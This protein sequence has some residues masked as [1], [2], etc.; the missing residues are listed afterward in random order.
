[1]PFS[2][3]AFTHLFDWE[4]DPQRQEKIVNSR[5]EAE[6]D[7]IDT[8]LSSLAAKGFASGTVMLFVQT[9]A[10]TGWTKGTTHNNKALR[11]VTGSVGSGGTIAFTT[12][13]GS[14]S[15]DAT[16]ITAATMP[17][18]GHNMEGFNGNSDG[19]P[20]TTGTYLST[21]TA[22]GSGLWRNSTNISGGAGIL[23]TGSGGSHTHGIDLSVQYVDVIIATKD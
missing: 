19:S 9:N 12:A 11:V 13:F 20:A 1:M 14:R 15:T 18:H 2:G 17:S 16:T 21:N 4:K 8:A 3:D 7:G 23:A 10:P 5:L 22:G 6:F